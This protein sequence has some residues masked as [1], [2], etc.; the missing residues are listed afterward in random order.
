MADE[1]Q[2]EPPDPN[3]PIE[4]EDPNR[5]I[6]RRTAGG[7]IYSISASAVTILL[8]FIRSTLLLRLLL[9]E[10]FG[11]TTLALL[12]L[13]LVSQIFG[14]GYDGAF[15][16]RKDGDEN[17]R[18]TYFTLRVGSTILGAL[19][20]GLLIPVLMIIYPD[21]PQLAPV[22]L[23]YAGLSI[24]K[25]L[26]APQETILIKRLAFR[27]IS[28][29]DVAS[30]IVMTIVAPLMAWQGFGLWSIVGERAAGTFTRFTLMYIVYRPWRPRLG[31]QKNLVRWFFSFGSRMW[32]STNFTFIIDH[33]DDWFVGTFL[34]SG[35]LGIYSRAYQYARYP[36]KVVANPILQVFFPAFSRLQD[37]RQRLSRAFFRA[38]SLMLRLGGLFSLL[39]IFT[40]PQFIPLLFGDKWLPMVTVF[41]LM[42]IYTLLDPL[43]MGARNLLM[44]TGYP[45]VVMRVS[46]AQILLFIPAV[47]GL[48]LWL[49]IEGVALAANLMVLLGTSLLFHQTKRITN[50]SQRALWLWP[51]M[52]M[53]FISG[54]MVA[55]NPLW[56][57]LSPWLVMG[58]KTAIIVPLYGG[59][60]WLM[61]R[62]Q[63][64]TG[65]RMLIG[66]LPRK[67]GFLG[68][69]GF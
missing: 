61:E 31:W 9:P 45:G 13:G 16:H 11:V 7:S 18:T 28:V 65:G 20:T 49:N 37:D 60:L 39:L 4:P 58:L 29:M 51:I 44:A 17:L 69:F 42:I 38:A 21:E 1:G 27:E 34:G 64:R 2:I 8:G 62:E 54:L 19:V 24:L 68:R 36:R 48:G 14:F 67:P 43:S 59:I 5:D 57:E 26:N 66:L 25:G 12:Y 32:M 3:S 55:I 15:I 53:L 46:L 30:S 52:A 22:L 47:V 35:P 41:Q 63:I 40:A 50:Y 33:F 10:H 56:G 6:A 23:A